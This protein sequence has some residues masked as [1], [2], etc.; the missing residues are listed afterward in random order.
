MKAD[1]VF[2][3]QY[4][5]EYHFTC[6]FRIRFS[7]IPSFINRIVTDRDFF[8]VIDDFDVSCFSLQGDDKP[9]R[10]AKAGFAP[11]SEPPVNILIKA[12]VLEFNF[13]TQ[14]AA[15]RRDAGLSGNAAGMYG[16][17]RKGMKQ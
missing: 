3:K 2:T 17:P 12:R 13:S 1:Y 11:E 9:G 7:S 5:T 6:K 10:D 8:F 15:S 16:G 4:Y 14:N